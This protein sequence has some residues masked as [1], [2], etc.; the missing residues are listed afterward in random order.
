[1]NAP[2]L[3]ELELKKLKYV[4]GGVP[5]YL[6]KCTIKIF[7]F[8]G[9]WY[10]TDFFVATSSVVS[11]K[12]RVILA[13]NYCVCYFCLRQFILIRNLTP[14]ALL[15]AELHRFTCVR[16]KREYPFD[17]T[18]FL[19]SSPK[20]PQNIEEESSSSSADWSP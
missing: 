20:L 8:A 14:L 9:R 2:I 15:R 1:M 4:L 19:R 3:N 13:V 10:L 17:T 7:L 16:C 5:P 11:L 18:Q 6:Q 12:T